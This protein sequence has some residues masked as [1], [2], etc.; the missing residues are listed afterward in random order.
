MTAP[1]D[2]S[3]LRVL[4]VGRQ[5]EVER[6][7]RPDE[8]W[9]RPKDLHDLSGWDLGP[10]GLCQGEICIPLEGSASPTRDGELVCVSELWRKLGR[11]VLHDAT[12]TTWFLGEAAEDRA[13][14]L[15]SLEAPDFTLPDIE[16]K[17]HSL[18]DY[19]GKKVFLTTWA[20]W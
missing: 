1:N 10:E 11:P 13:R 8:L 2:E 6:S 7:D 5:L 18:S 4:T 12:R 19:R 16:G 15:D 17:L 14:A 9:L 3:G 20:S